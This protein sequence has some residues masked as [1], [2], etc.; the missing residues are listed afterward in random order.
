MFGIPLFIYLFTKEYLLKASKK[1]THISL[2]MNQ[3]VSLIEL[4]R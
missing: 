1:T 2:L 3:F 4:K